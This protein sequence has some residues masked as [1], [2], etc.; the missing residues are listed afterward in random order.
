[1]L[2]LTATSFVIN[3]SKSVGLRPIK[4]FFYLGFC[5]NRQLTKSEGKSAKKKTTRLSSSVI[6]SSLP[7]IGTNDKRR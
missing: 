4:H 7:V 3:D 5:E 2:L 1:M 6:S